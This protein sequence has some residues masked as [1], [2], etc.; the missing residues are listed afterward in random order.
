MSQQLG[1]IS[2]NLLLNT[3]G[4]S[5]GIKSAIR[6]LDVL[7]RSGKE[8]GVFD[9]INLS[10]PISEIDAL[11]VAS[12][13]LQKELSQIGKAQTNVSSETDKATQAVDQHEQSQKKL[14][15]TSVTLGDSLQNLGL[16]FQ[17]IKAVASLL[18]ST[19]MDLINTA[20]KTETLGVVV[21]RMGQTAGYTSG[22][23]D[24]MVKSIEQKGIT[25]AES[26]DAVIKMIQADLD[27]SRASELARL[28]QNA[29]VNAQINSSE[30]LGRII[31]G[32]TTL[33]PIILRSVGIMVNYDQV[34]KDTANSLNKKVAELTNAEKQQAS[35]SAV[36]Q[37]GEKIIGTY[38]DAM[39]TA[40]KRAGSY[41]RYLEALKVSLGELLLPAFGKVVDIA[42]KFTKI[43][44]D[45]PTP[46]QRLILSVSALAAAWLY[47]NSS[48][49]ASAKWA[50]T[51]FAIA[52]LLPAPLRI[53]IGV[54]MAL[55]A[56]MLILAAKVTIATAG[57]NILLG[58][59]FAGIALIGEGILSLKSFNEEIGELSESVRET[60]AEI[61]DANKNLSDLKSLYDTLSANTVMTK[62]EQDKYNEKLKSL[63]E[64][65]PSIVTG[66]DSVTGSYQTNADALRLVIQAEEDHLK[67]KHEKYLYDLADGVI[68]V[69][70]ESASLQKE[71]DKLNKVVD[72][73]TQLV[74]EL[75][76]R[77]EELRAEIEQMDNSAEKNLYNYRLL[78]DEYVRNERSLGVLKKSIGDKRREMALLLPE[79]Q[80]VTANWKH[81]IGE[82]LKTGS[83]LPLLEFLKARLTDSAVATDLVSK[84][85]KNLSDV[86]IASMLGIT[87]NASNLARAMH[88]IALGKQAIVG[89]NVEMGQALFNVARGI[90]FT[91]PST[92]T[93]PGTTQTKGGKTSKEKEKEILTSLQEQLK[94]LKEIDNELQL[95]AGFQG[96]VNDL[97]DRRLKL[98]RDMYYTVTG[99]KVAEKMML[100]DYIKVITG[101]IP[102][103]LTGIMS[104]DEL[105]KDVSITDPSL[106]A[107]DK[108]GE[109]AIKRAE[110][111]ARIQGDLNEQITQ[112]KIDLIEDEFDRRR[113]EI[114][115]TYQQELQYALAL[116]DI[117]DDQRNT[118]FSLAR[119]KR[120]REIEL[121]DDEKF[122]APFNRAESI[123]QNIQNIFQF[124]AHTVYAKFLDA[125][126]ITQQIVQLFQTLESLGALKWIGKILGA[127]FGFAAGGPVGAAA[128]A[129][130]GGALGGMPG[131]GSMPLSAMRMMT[132]QRIK[133]DLAVHGKI[134]G[135]DIHL[136]NKRVEYKESRRKG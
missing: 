21:Q 12:D 89:G 105:L 119:Q 109:L 68:K 129:T 23:I 37:A 53:V 120:D 2:L 115:F 51:F 3:K 57:M 9:K 22:Q 117:T 61:E 94:T 41:A 74:E 8:L 90:T 130:A 75:T 131:G 76:N 32:M 10:K 133:L 98:L 69:S 114:D 107:A 78:T 58:M 128:G 83:L 112:K 1:D 82:A 79:L 62:E 104:V 70:K 11:A 135:E 81:F 60:S 96:T 67:I 47:L 65:Y 28:A 4:F 124:G 132:P 15:A 116:K 125:L 43:V 73:S 24:R 33:N 80:K 54:V 101:D 56:A 64:L 66:I 93:S 134:K 84:A 20:A 26:R 46:V 27:L 29:A 52:Q 13:K 44:T 7:S 99:I 108:L 102:G 92:D 87:A 91:T 95:N 123:A 113:A 19:I 50:G 63:A 18:K 31:H 16:R 49:S 40:G 55:S 71:Y 97:L 17:G 121:L 111:I 14:Q 30:A 110:E 126:R 72:H 42:T 35:F 106:K 5:E 127:V 34:F 39:D 118:L 85:F 6:M 88:L 136:T 103:E 38:E 86:A 25:L 45:A 77:Q 48:M 36:M 100:N 122:I 59:I